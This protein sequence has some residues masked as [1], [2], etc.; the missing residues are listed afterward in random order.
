MAIEA[1]IR[2]EVFGIS[3]EV[4][5]GVSSLLK[6]AGL[7][8]KGLIQTLSFATQLA[9]LS[10]LKSTAPIWNQPIHCQKSPGQ[11]VKGRGPMLSLSCEE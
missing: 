9:D 7:G 3:D 6:D 5:D 1:E 11:P 8:G 4:P 2:K 10:L